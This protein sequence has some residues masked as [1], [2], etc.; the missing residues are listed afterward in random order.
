MIRNREE[1]VSRIA[2]VD[3]SALLTSSL[4]NRVR[5]MLVDHMMPSFG[6]SEKD[7]LALILRQEA[8]KL[9]R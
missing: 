9:R 3:V 4:C 5:T 7:L 2:W 1:V 8:L 6:W